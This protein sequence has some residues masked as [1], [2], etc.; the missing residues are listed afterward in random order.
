[1]RIEIVGTIPKVFGLS[2]ADLRSA[3]AYFARRSRSRLVRRPLSG[4]VC[5]EPVWH[6][7]VVNLVRDAE[8]AECH[9]AIMGVEG[10]TDVITQAY[11]AIPPETPGLYGEL[12]VNAD[13]ALRAAPKRNGWRPADELLLYVAHGMDH[14]SGADDRSEADY[15]RMRRRELGWMKDWKRSW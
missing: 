8:S 9:R 10:A 13:Q 1:M 14:L 7:V 11:D 3:A 6:E 15:L 2:R 4:P 12:I 5:R